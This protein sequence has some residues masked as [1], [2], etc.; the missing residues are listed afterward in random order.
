M[1]ATLITATLRVLLFR[2]TQRDVAFLD[3]LLYLT[4]AVTLASGL[5]YL[6]RGFLRVSTRDV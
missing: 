1:F 2:A 6:Y 4:A 5:H 3:P